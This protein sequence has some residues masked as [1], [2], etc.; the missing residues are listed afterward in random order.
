MTNRGWIFISHSHQDIELVRRIRNHFE[1]LGF[2]PLMFY[3]KC[4]SDDCEIESLIKREIDEREWFVYADSPNA[5]ESKWVKTERE[6]IETSEGKKIFVIDLESDLDTQLKQIE[7]ISRQMKVFIAHSH[8]DAE[9]YRKIKNKLEEKDMLVISAE[10]VLPGD[11][12]E[13]IVSENISKAYRDGF[14]VLLITESSCASADI[15]HEIKQAIKEKG[16]IVPVYVGNGTLNPELGNLIGNVQGVSISASPTNDELNKVVDKILHRVEFYS[17]DFTNSFGYRS[18]EVI[19]LPPI[20]YIDNLTF[21]DC[22][23]LKCVYVPN[24]VVYI[25]PN[26]FDD[27]KGILIKCYAGSYCEEYC[28]KNNIKFEII[29]ETEV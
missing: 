7:H 25:T 17:N 15:T 6:Y 28:I 29:T 3:L 13:S 24:S 18:A 8:K 5:R 12:F 1:K 9:L 27:H 26:A 2:E 10:N 4:L 20:S 11:D 23:N 21:W 16:K 22:A 14:V 19:H